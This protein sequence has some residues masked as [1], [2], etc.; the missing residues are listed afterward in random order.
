M[1]IAFLERE[2]EMAWRAWPWG[3]RGVGGWGEASLAPRPCRW[4]HKRQHSERKAHI[5][6]PHNQECRSVPAGV[7][8]ILQECQDH[9]EL[10]ISHPPSRFPTHSA[11]RRRLKE[12]PPCFMTGSPASWLWGTLWDGA[13][14][15]VCVCVSKCLL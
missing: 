1:F 3:R 9:K 13:A 4:V 8:N 10:I 6:Q 12:W 11:R 5:L 2:Q 7:K 15:C 14:V